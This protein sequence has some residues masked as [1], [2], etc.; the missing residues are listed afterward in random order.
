VIE[1]VTEWQSR[2]LDTIYPI[3]YL[4]CIVLKICQDKQAHGAQLSEVCAVERF[5]AVT[6]DL[7]AI[8]QSTTERMHYYPSINLLNAGMINT[9][10]SA[11]PGIR[12]GGT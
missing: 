9:R 2:P 6:K 1:Q 11:S 5:K 4:D 3:V 8:Y 7:K 12:T 10:K